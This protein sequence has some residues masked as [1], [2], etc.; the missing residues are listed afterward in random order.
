MAFE[1]HGLYPLEMSLHRI[2]RAWGGCRGKI[3]EIRTISGPPH[4]SLIL[5]GSLA[6][7][8][9]TDVVGEYQQRLLGMDM[10]LDPREPFPVLLKFISTGENHPI[11][12][13]PN[14]H[15]T[16]EKGLPM[17][18]KEK[19]WHILAKK[20]GARIYLGFKDRMTS[21]G[22]LESLKGNYLLHL[23]NGIE[24]TPG[25]VYT[26]PAGRIHGIGRGVTLFEVQ[27]HSD[28]VFELHPHRG[29][30]S[31]PPVRL[32]QDAGPEK[33]LEILDMEPL[34]PRPVPPL[35]MH[36]D[37][38]RIRYLALTPRFFLRRLRI[39]GSFEIPF[40]GKRFVIYT[41]LRGAGWLRWGLSRIYAKI[42][43]YQSLLVPAAEEDL[44]FET[45]G[46]LEV[47]ETSIPNMAGEI[48]KEMGALRISKERFAGLGGEDYRRVLETL[49][50]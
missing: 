29:P 40:A 49:L 6:G 5:N 43:P 3:G 13:H 32:K 38:C 2:R 44:L 34:D 20:P 41:G 1:K 24:V 31:V 9:L 23:L 48:Q 8:R 42:Q 16:M 36:S 28:L 50:G 33:A 22:I 47:L 26:V 39:E 37:N 45:E 35:D 21:E 12:V 46:E 25:D 10:E 30:H 19:I 14:D 11:Q 15:Y 17:V 27:N 18:G 7:N 4:E